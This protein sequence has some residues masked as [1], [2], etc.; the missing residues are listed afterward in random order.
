MQQSF[1]NNS[2]KKI[3]Y[4]ITIKYYQTALFISFLLGYLLQ[5]SFKNS[6]KIRLIQLE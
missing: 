1:K 4:K 2:D 3:S 6:I 5:K